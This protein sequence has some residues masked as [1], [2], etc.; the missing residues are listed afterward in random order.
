[1]PLLL[2][3]VLLALMLQRLLLLLAFFVPAAG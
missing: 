3:R 1:V 2:G